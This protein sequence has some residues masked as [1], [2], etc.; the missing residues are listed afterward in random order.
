MGM[1]CLI[2]VVIRQYVRQVKEKAIEFKGGGNREATYFFLLDNVC[3][4]RSRFSNRTVS[5]LNRTV[6]LSIGTVTYIPFKK[7]QV[8]TSYTIIVIVSEILS[9][10]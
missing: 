8:A 10:V 1:Q 4:E 5:H 7:L 3:K 6:I 2:P 9:P